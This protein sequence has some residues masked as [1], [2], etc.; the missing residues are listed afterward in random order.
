MKLNLGNTVHAILMGFFFCCLSAAAQT[1]GITPIHLDWPVRDMSDLLDLHHESVSA[2]DRSH[3]MFFD[4]GAWHG[5]ALPPANDTGTG[6]IGPFL[7]ATDGGRWAGGRFGTVAVADAITGA[8]IP[9]SACDH[10]GVSLPGALA[11]QACGPGLILTETLFYAAPSATL[12]RVTLTA[13]SPRTLRV[14]LGT[15]LAESTRGPNDVLTVAV[16]GGTRATESKPG[17]QSALTLAERM[18][19]PGK[20]AV[21]YLQ[22]NYLPT[23]RGVALS[24][25]NGSATEAWSRAGRALAAV[26]CPEWQLAAS[27]RLARGDTPPQHQGGRHP[28]Q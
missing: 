24:A 9:L 7:G 15:G 4:E 27:P 14:T 2:T 3:E 10:G 13:A 18:V 11:R 19:V 12:I 22:Q 8:T 1:P 6:F 16:V 20:P 5:Y 21:F 23:S 26:P 28:T 17:D 25:W